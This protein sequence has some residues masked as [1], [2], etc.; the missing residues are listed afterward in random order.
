MADKTW[1]KVR[2]I[3]DIVLQKEFEEREDYILEA[4]RDDENLL[5]SFF[6]NIAAFLF[7]VSKV[8][9]IILTYGLKNCRGIK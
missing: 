8:F 9:K 4:C 7:L 6:Y 3:F 5:I 1:Q 2:E